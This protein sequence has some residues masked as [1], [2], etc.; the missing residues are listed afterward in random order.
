MARPLEPVVP[1]ALADVLRRDPGDV[2]GFTILVVTSDAAGWPV[3]AMVSPGELAFAAD[4]R[5]TLALWPRSTAAAN[6]TRTG[7]VSLAFVLDG[8]NYVL[9][10]EARRLEDLDVPGG[11]ELACFSLDV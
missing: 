7:R 8:A 3:V 2:L 10:A 1:P 4:D 5:V 9:H 6:L 11:G